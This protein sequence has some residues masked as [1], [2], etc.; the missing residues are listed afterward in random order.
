[1]AVVFEYL[2]I[3]PCGDATG[4]GKITAGDALKTLRVAVGSG[5]CP[6]KFCDYTGD[7]QITA[8]DALAILRVAVGQ[9]IPPMCPDAAIADV[10]MI[11]RQDD[12]PECIP[13]MRPDAAVAD[14]AMIVR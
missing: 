1:M 4:D 14:V 9:D 13:P 8:S 6:E 7:G 11:V 10:A 12:R 5:T 2:R 3:P